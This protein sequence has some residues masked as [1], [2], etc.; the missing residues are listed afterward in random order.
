[1]KAVVFDNI[2][3]LISDYTKPKSE[4]GHAIIRVIKSGIVIPISK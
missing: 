3:N 1:M 2:L 4:N